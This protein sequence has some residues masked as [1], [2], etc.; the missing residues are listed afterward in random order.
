MAGQA[1]RAI[2]AFLIAGDRVLHG[3]MNTPV[4]IVDEAHIRRNCE[5]LRR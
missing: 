3:G 5:V 2:A 4:F 1:G